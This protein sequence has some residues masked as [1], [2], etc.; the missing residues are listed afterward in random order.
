MNLFLDL[1]H[2]DMRDSI[3]AIE[4]AGD[5]LK[6][7][8]LGLGV[9]EVHEGQFDADP[10]LRIVRVCSCSLDIVKTYSVEESQIPVLRK[11]IPGNRIGLTTDSEYSLDG[12]VHDH[13]TLGSK[14]V[15]ENLESIGDK[16]AR[17]GEGVEDTEDPDEGNLSVASR[18]V[19]PVGI[20]VDGASDGPGDEGADH[21]DG[22]GQE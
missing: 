17:P 2:G 16:K 5:L 15:W 13:E 19:S 22:R 3:L 14:S 4:N 6:G 9:D 11:T 1:S 8:S 21:A 10:A 18:L 12:D 20:L 7:W